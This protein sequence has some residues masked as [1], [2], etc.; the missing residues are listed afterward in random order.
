[1]TLL[2]SGAG[3]MSDDELISRP[4]DQ[5]QRRPLDRTDSADIPLYDEK[6]TTGRSQMLLWRNVGD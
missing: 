2:V 5:P 3:K 1:V 6:S 4:T